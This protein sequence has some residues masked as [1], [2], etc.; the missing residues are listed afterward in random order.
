[1]PPL[2]RS[3]TRSVLNIDEAYASFEE[4][5]AALEEGDS[6]RDRVVR[7]RGYADTLIS[8]IDALESETSG[9]FELIVRRETLQLELTEVRAQLDDALA[10]AIDDQLFFALTGY[11]DLSAPPASRSEHLSEEQFVRYRRLA[12]LQAD[13][14]IATEL[15]ANAFTLSDASLIEPLRERFESTVSRIDRNLSALAGSPFHAEA[16]PVFGRLFALGSGED[17]VFDLFASELRIADRQAELLD[18]NRDLSVEVIAEVDGLVSAAQASAG[19][20]TEA[21]TQAIF[22]GRVLLLAINVISITGAL[23]ITWLFIG[24]VL[25]RRIGCFRSGCAAWPRETWRPVPRSG[26]GTR[27]RRWPPRSTCSGVTPWKCNA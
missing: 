14:N 18:L 10:P 6:E 1:M 4:Q 2:R 15:L 22:T 3:S 27:S 23:L 7:I 13:V 8:N 21:S 16:A 11:R 25:L 17:S 26:G 5:L 19:D 20:A 9:V 24:R 12:E